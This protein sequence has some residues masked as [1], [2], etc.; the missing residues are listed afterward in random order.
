LT[1]CVERLGE[2]ESAAN[3]AKLFWPLGNHD[4]RFETR[5][6]QAA[7]QYEGVR[8]FHL[9]DHFPAW[10]PCWSVWINDDVVVKHKFKNGI[11]AT[12]NNTM[13]GGK[14]IVTGHL[15]SLKVTPL[16]DYTQT[17]WGVDTG[18]LAEPGGPQFVNYTEDN[19]TNWRSG[20]AV[21]TFRDGELLDPELCRVRKFDEVVFRGMVLDVSDE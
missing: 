5:L 8:G 4:A 15:H 3:G 17:R 7:P 2:I 12:H 1:A 6:A 14:T 9:K 13:W 19:P 16:T 11:H 18:T 21:L 20:F 10:A